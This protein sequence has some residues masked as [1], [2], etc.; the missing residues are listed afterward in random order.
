MKGLYQ[1]IQI[2]FVINDNDNILQT[3]H[4]THILVFD[5]AKYNARFLT[6]ELYS[7]HIYEVLPFLNY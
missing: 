7:S 1:L 6:I 2:L 4:Q 5:N 3:P